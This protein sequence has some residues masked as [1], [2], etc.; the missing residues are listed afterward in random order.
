[1]TGATASWRGMPATP[2]FAPAKAAF[3]VKTLRKQKFQEVSITSQFSHY[4][5]RKSKASEISV[6]VE[7]LPQGS[8]ENF[9]TESLANVRTEGSGSDQ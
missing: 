2:A 6:S 5:I 4:S 7:F 9:S 8:F 3:G 1:M